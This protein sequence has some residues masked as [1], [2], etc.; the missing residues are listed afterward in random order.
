MSEGTIL[1]VGGISFTL[2]L[3]NIV[4]IYVAAIAMFRV[5]EVYTPDSNEKSKFWRG[6]REMRE[7]TKVVDY[8]ELKR[9][10]NIPDDLLDELKVLP[11]YHHC[12]FPCFL[13]FCFVLG[14]GA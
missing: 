12:F 4:C 13:F 5:K 11:F 3:L 6:L 2:Y 14:L 8:N 1:R 7:A 9:E 10:Y